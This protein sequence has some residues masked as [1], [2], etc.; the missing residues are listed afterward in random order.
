MFRVL[1]ELFVWEVGMV[2]CCKFAEMRIVEFKGNRI[3]LVI[4]VDRVSEEVIFMCLRVEV[5]IHVVL[6]EES[7]VVG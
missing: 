2:L 6:V 7:G 5:F 1:V 3:D 4:D